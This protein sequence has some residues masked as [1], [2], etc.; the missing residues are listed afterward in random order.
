[1]CGCSET[2]GGGVYAVIIINSRN[3][4]FPYLYTEGMAKINPNL[5]KIRQA[6]ISGRRQRSCPDYFFMSATEQKKS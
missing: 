3:A 2:P 6:H 1:M 4:A 5:E